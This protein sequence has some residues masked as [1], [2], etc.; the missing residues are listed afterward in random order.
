M[1]A[2]VAA[3]LGAAACEGAVDVARWLRMVCALLRCSVVDS[4]CM[5]W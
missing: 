3:A 5:Q 4:R 1:V 2:V